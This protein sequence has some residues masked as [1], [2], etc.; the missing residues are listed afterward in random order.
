MTNQKI[1]FGDDIWLVEGTTVSVAGFTYGTR[2]AVIRLQS[3]ALVVWSPIALTEPLKAELT[4]LGSVEHLVAPNHLH[5]LFLGEWAAAYPN[6]TVYAPPDLRKKR[7][8]LTF[9]ADLTDAQIPAWADQ[10]DHVVV[11]GNLITTEV[12]FFHRPSGTVLFT[13]LLQQF[14]KGWHKGWRAVIARLDLMVA[15]EPSVP[16]KFRVAFLGRGKART[17]IRKILEWPAR[18][19]VMA[20]GTP[21]RTD[22]RAYLKRAFGWLI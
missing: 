7:G 14:P 20:H 9:D 16:R 17:A 4:A 2:M 21:V 8:D 12:V 5:H 10:I 13:D 6:A 19:I 15:A 11:R 22:A 3:G 1:E 18:Q